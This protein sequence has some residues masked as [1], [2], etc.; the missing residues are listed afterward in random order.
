MSNHKE[1]RE[2]KPNPYKTH[3]LFERKLFTGMGE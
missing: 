2:F 3:S 1:I